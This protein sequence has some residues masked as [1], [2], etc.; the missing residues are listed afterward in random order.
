MSIE[1]ELFDSAVDMQVTVAGSVAVP[2]V[3]VPI[4][5]PLF[6]LSLHFWKHF[7]FAPTNFTRAFVSPSSHF[8]SV[9]EGTLPPFS[10]Q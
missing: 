2:G 9:F 4:V 3:Q 1:A 8:P 6:W 7:P 10:T 5:F